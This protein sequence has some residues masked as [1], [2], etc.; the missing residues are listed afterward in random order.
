MTI[1]H[2]AMADSVCWYG[3]V[4]R[5]EDGH[6]LRRALD[7]GVRGQRKVKVGQKGIERSGLMEKARTLIVGKKMHIA[8][9]GEL[10]VLISLPIV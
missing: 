4:L 6:V 8:D 7:F 10:L 2:L 9:Q 3:Y 5:I 1:N